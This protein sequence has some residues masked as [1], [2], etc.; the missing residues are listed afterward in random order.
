MRIGIALVA[1]DARADGIR[2]LLR[3]RVDTVVSC[4]PGPGS[5][6][7]ATICRSP[8]E[9][10]TG[11]MRIRVVRVYD[12]YYVEEVPMAYET[13]GQR[14]ARDRPAADCAVGLEGASS[15]GAGAYENSQGCTVSKGTV[16][17]PR[18]TDR[19]IEYGT[20]IVLREVQTPT[21]PDL[22]APGRA[23]TS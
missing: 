12:E 17:R 4:S 10:L 13:L 16:D 1:R 19:I 2:L 11:G 22:L 21:R 15:S 5:T 23:A 14:R 6:C 3:T 9:T 18:A 8:A 20:K 7:W